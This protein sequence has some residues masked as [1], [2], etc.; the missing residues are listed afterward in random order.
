[1]KVKCRGA[2]KNLFKFVGNLHKTGKA[3][4]PMRKL[5][6]FGNSNFQTFPTLL[7]TTFANVTLKTTH[8]LS[9]VALY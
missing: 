2:M 3:V 9:H 5:R 6:L 8:S 7:H 1:M 4:S